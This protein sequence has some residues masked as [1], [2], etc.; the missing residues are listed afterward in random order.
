M[1]SIA[2]TTSRAAA[3]LVDAGGRTR[4][5]FEFV[6]ASGRRLF[7]GVAAP[8]AANPT[9]AVVICSPLFTDSIANYR[10]E[11]ALARRLAEHGVAVARFH[12]RGTGHSDGLATD[13]DLGGLIEDTKAVAGLIDS[14]FGRLP[15]GFVGTRVG[16]VVA[17]AAAQGDR[18]VLLLW[19]PTPDPTAYLREIFRVRRMRGLV[20]R[21]PEQTTAEQLF[22][23]LAAGV[24]V[25]ALG[26]RVTA[27]LYRDLVDTSLPDELIDRPGA[28]LLVGFRDEAEPVAEIASL[29]GD[30]RA[31]GWEI[32]FDTVAT[33]ANWW[34]L[35]A[36][37]SPPPEL[38]ERSAKWLVH[39]LAGGAA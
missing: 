8:M 28:A 1:G 37:A 31:A 22:G 30:L 12:Y 21:R 33:E 32:E 2:S 7:V 14:R 17:A 38:I 10:R 26:Y 20:L 3:V 35:G 24:D 15:C 34:L 29:G 18:R 16:A 23:Q 4:E 13:L 9:A 36:Q 27:A 19:E 11:V 5:E 25:D 6:G 39:R